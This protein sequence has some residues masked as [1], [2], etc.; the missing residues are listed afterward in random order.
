LIWFT[1]TDAHCTTSCRDLSTRCTAFASGA[2]A[3]SDR[4]GER[5]ALASAALRSRDRARARPGRWWSDAIKI[6]VA[7]W[8]ACLFFF[9]VFFFFCFAR[10][11]KPSE[12]LLS[13]GLKLYLQEAPFGAHAFSQEVQNNDYYRRMRA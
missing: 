2:L 4:A 7:S 8:R 12:S 11:V 3:L 1:R 13:E 9:F 5:P 10:V 6:R